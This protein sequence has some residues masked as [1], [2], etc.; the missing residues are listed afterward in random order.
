MSA[1]PDILGTI[2]LTPSRRVRV[3]M[4]E[5]KGARVLDLRLCDRLGTTWFPGKSGVTVPLDRLDEL[6]RLVDEAAA[7]ATA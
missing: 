2:D 3:A 6:S 1:A 7:R 4:T 5:D